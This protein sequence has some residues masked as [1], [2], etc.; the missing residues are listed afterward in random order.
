MNQLKVKRKRSVDAKQKIN[1]VHDQQR[2]ENKMSDLDKKNQYAI[3]V[4]QEIMFGRLEN[5]E[6]K[7]GAVEF[8][9]KSRRVYTVRLDKPLNM[10]QN[11]RGNGDFILKDKYINFI[12]RI[13]NISLGS[14]SSIQIT[15][16]LPVSFD[17]ITGV[18]SI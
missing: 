5:L 12:E 8:T 17:I 6:I 9:E 15:D 14:I 7:A 10:Y 13:K 3:S 1:N 2:K 16:G 11:N 18:N 4:M